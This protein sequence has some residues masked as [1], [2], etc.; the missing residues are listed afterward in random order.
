MS[1]SPGVVPRIFINGVEDVELRQGLASLSVHVRE[2]QAAAVIECVA[3]LPTASEIKVGVDGDDLVLRQGND[4]DVFFSGRLTDVELRVLPPD[5]PRVVLRAAGP[6][7][8]RTDRPPVALRFG[9]DVASGSVRRDASGLTAQ[10]VTNRWDLEV[11]VPVD[12]ITGHDAFDG[13]FRIV[14][15]RCYLDPRSGLLSD[16]VATSA[17]A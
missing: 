10:L 9:A 8:S 14:E 4:D 2:G 13:R 12:L 15:N 1:P 17:T 16:L 11:G 3:A 5:A 7:A 6:A